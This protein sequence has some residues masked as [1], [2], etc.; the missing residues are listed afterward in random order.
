MAIE[1]RD[2]SII[3]LLAQNN[4]L[5]R[6]KSAILFEDFRAIAHFILTEDNVDLD[7]W[8]RS[9]HATA[10]HYTVTYG[11]EEF[12][13]CLVANGACPGLE[14]AKGMTLLEVAVLMDAQRCAPGLA[15]N[16]ALDLVSRGVFL[17]ADLGRKQLASSLIGTGR[18]HFNAK[19]RFGN[20]TLPI[21]LVKRQ[22]IEPALVVAAEC[23]D[24]LAE[25]DDL[26]ATFARD[27][28]SER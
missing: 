20:D 4:C 19:D 17:C 12:C 16:Y 21:H 10:L 7:R 6:T 11:K 9:M 24:C 23:H 3:Q 27:A 15:Q 8:S 25:K 5:D 18:I 14:H 2:P 13:L 1:A 28:V 22:M 26:C